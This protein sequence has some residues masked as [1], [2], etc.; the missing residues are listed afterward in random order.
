MNSWPQLIV[1]FQP[2]ALA[3]SWNGGKT[4]HTNHLLARTPS[5]SATHLKNL[6]RCARKPGAKD[7]RVQG[8][9]GDVSTFPL[10]LGPFVPLPLSLQGFVYF[11]KRLGV[12]EFSRARDVEGSSGD[13]C[14]IFRVGDT[15]AS[16]FGSNL[17]HV[18]P[19]NNRSHARL[20][21]SVSSPRVVDH[22]AFSGKAWSN[23]RS[24]GARG[25]GAE[26]R[27]FLPLIPRPLCSSTLS[28]THI[29][30]HHRAGRFKS[31]SSVFITISVTRA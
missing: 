22:E 4:F 29:I 18:C 7:Q 30:G 13:L 17:C 27:K 31:G 24:K 25:S 26:G 15:S 20:K 9:K 23:F 11:L 21:W 14:I 8:E 3:F 16:L 5:E 19:A 28:A 10:P 2:F 1:I 6:A 12:R